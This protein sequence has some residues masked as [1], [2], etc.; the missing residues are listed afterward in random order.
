MAAS[1]DIQQR[2]DRV[3]RVFLWSLGIFAGS[4]AFSILGILSLTLYPPALEFFAPM[5]SQLIQGPTWVYMTLLGIIPILMY[6]PSLGARRMTIF[7]V[8]GCLIGGGSELIGT[9]GWL[10][11]LVGLSW[12]LPFGDY[13]YTGWLGPEFAGHVPYFIPLSWFAMA[14]ISLDL[15][16][17]IPTGRFTRVLIATTFMVLWDVS[18]DPAMNGAGSA[19]GTVPFW[20]YAADGFYYGMPLSNWVG[21]FVVSY[22]IMWGYEVL[23]G[24]LDHIHSY[25]PVVYLLNCLFP[26]L[27]LAVQ[28]LIIPL[29]V[30]II[31]TAIPFVTVHYFGSGSLLPSYPPHQRAITPATSSR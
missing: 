8:W 3:H 5:L 21:W 28:G 24:G 12:S 7:L 27:I 15:A 6:T 26:L 2:S 13:T 18:L 22:I 10:S 31:A 14:I 23:G 16:R 20:E 4:I 25:A 11:D 9:T 29:F 1:T 19:I 17:R 30:G